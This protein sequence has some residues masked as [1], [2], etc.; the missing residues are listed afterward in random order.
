VQLSGITQIY[1]QQIDRCPH[2]R[3]ILTISHQGRQRLA[4]HV[5]GLLQPPLLGE[6]VLPASVQGL[7]EKFLRARL[8]SLL[9]GHCS[10]LADYCQRVGVVRAKPPLIRI[11]T[12][13]I[14][15]AIT[16]AHASL[17]S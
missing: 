2:F 1:R 16:P 3:V 11:K 17:L 9:L 5:D 15:T 13:F 6:E 7:L 10:H 4:A 14:A 12:R 8:V